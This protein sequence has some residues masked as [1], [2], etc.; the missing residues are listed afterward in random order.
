MELKQIKID[1]WKERGNV[2]FLILIAVALFAALSYAVTQS[3]RSGGGDASGETALIGSAQITQYPASVRTSL[4][5]M[6]I[7]GSDV[8]QLQFNAPAD[9]GNCTQDGAGLNSL[10][11]FHPDGGGATFVESPPDIMATG[12]NGTWSINGENEINLVGTSTAGDT[13]GDATADVIAFL[14]DITSTICQKINDEL[15]I[16]GNI[17]TETGIVFSSATM[18]SNAAGPAG[19]ASDFTETGATIGSPTGTDVASLDGQPF[20]CFQQPAGTY[21]YYH[22]LIER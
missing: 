18:V 8:R 12:A 11:V 13:V 7:G 20:G 4:V 19:E 14:S 6:I 15:G 10:C 22:V 17:P 1:R 5:R 21:H 2:L 3:T 9:F 16:T